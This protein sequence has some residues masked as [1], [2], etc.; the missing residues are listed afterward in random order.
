MRWAGHAARIMERRSV[1]RVLVRKPDGKSPLGIPRRRWE[2]KIKM[3]LKEGG[4]ATDRI[5]LAQ[6]NDGWR[7]NV[8]AVMIVRVS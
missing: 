8:K 7:A 2:D 5:A 4:G 6:D 3:D 1:Y